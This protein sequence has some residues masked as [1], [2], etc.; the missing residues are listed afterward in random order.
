MNCHIR[1]RHKKSE[2]SIRGKFDDLKRFLPLN[3]D[4]Q[5]VS[6]HF[7]FRDNS[8][9]MI[10]VTLIPDSPVSA[11]IGID[12]AKQYLSGLAR[13]ERGKTIRIARKDLSRIIRELQSAA[14]SV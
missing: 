12:L 7:A 3:P 8:S 9:R 6:K 1:I 10:E 2:V 5:R 14:E 13:K 11:K 4:L